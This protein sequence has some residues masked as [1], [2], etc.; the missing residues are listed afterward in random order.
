MEETNMNTTNNCKTCNSTLGFG[1][2]SANK[3]CQC[4]SGREVGNFCTQIIGC[5]E[6]EDSYTNIASNC[7]TCDSSLGF[8]L[9]SATKSCQCASGKAIGNGCTQVIGCI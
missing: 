1:L 5:I 9:N 6:V 7:K 8:I 4:T 3:T 2:N